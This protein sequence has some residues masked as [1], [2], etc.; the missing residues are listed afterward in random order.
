MHKAEQHKQCTVLG[1]MTHAAA[2]EQPNGSANGDE[3]GDGRR[4]REALKALLFLLRRAAAKAATCRRDAEED[5]ALGRRKRARCKHTRDARLHR[6]CCTAHL[7]DEALRADVVLRA[8][9]EENLYQES[10]SSAKMTGSRM[11]F[12]SRG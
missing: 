8:A 10:E 11:A 2:L 5:G 6:G 4:R 12:A 3:S 1:P 9:G 7:P